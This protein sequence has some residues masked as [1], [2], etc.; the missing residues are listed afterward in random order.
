MDFLHYVTRINCLTGAIISE[1]HITNKFIYITKYDPPHTYPK[2]NCITD[3]ANL[4]ESGR[5][6]LLGPGEQRGDIGFGK[7]SI[8]TRH[9]ANFARYE[10]MC[11]RK[12]C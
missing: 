9:D 11:F 12:Y 8:K 5:N 3:N 2:F 6:C 10:K 7:S 4:K 1:T